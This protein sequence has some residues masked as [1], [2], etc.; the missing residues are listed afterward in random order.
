MGKIICFVKLLITSS[1]LISVS[2]ITLKNIV[3]ATEFQKELLWM[4][5]SST[6]GQYSTPKIAYRVKQETSAVS[7]LSHADVIP[8]TAPLLFPTVVGR[9]WILPVVFFVV[10]GLI[11]DGPGI[12]SIVSTARMFPVVVLVTVMMVVMLVVLQHQLLVVVTRRRSPGV[13]TVQQPTVQSL[14]Q[15][16]VVLSH[17][18]LLQVIVDPAVLVHG[19]NRLHHQL[20]GLSSRLLPAV[21]LLKI[22]GLLHTRDLHSERRS[23]EILTRALSFWSALQ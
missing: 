16:V 21:S 17:G 13:V 1:R 18:P 11:S 10:D 20:V 7:Y 9:C 2:K 12:F 5:D 14:L 22:V 19:R 8:L 6:D 4:F 15:L 3:L 23:A